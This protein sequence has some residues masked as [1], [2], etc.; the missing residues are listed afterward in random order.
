MRIGG[1]VWSGLLST[2]ETP[3]TNNQPSEPVTYLMG[4]A[5][6]STANRWGVWRAGEV[7]AKVSVDQRG[8]PSCG[9]AFKTA[10]A[11]NNNPPY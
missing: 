1:R 11:K 5:S 6:W 4:H 8:R 7:P 3:Q 10:Q 9:D 2:H